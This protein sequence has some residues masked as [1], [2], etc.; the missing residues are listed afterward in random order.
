MVWILFFCDYRPNWEIRLQL[1]QD[2][3]LERQVQV[4]DTNMQPD[5]YKKKTEFELERHGSSVG[6]QY[7]TC[8]GSSGQPQPRFTPLDRAM[9]Q[10][11]TSGLLKIEMACKHGSHG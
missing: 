10:H 7:R 4:L 1:G 11:Y 5:D 9:K 3:D 8:R 2:E 6:S